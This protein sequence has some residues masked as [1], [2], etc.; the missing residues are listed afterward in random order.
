MPLHHLAEVITTLWL[1]LNDATIYF[2]GKVHG[3]RID[4][5]MDSYERIVI[6]Y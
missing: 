6:G 3:N 2:I 4:Y 5:S 1:Y